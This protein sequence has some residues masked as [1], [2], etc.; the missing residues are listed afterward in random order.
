MYPRKPRFRRF[1]PTL[2]CISF[3][4]I[5]LFF[6]SPHVAF[7]SPAPPDHCFIVG[8]NPKA[9]ALWQFNS[10]ALCLSSSVCLSTRSP[11]D[12]FYHSSNFSSTRCSVVNPAFALLPNTEHLLT[13]DFSSCSKFQHEK[14]V[15]SH[16]KG[17]I[18]DTAECP[19]SVEQ[20][21]PLSLPTIRWNEHFT[22]LV[23]SYPYPKNIFHFSYLVASLPYFIDHLPEMIK[24]WSTPHEVDA[25]NAMYFRDM[26]VLVK[27]VTILMRTPESE[28]QNSRWQNDLLQIMI[29]HRL[30][31]KGINATLDFLSP[32]PD[33][34]HEY[35]CLRNAL[36]LGEQGHVN[37]WPFPNTTEI[38]MDGHSVHVDA[39]HFKRAVYKATKKVARLPEGNGGV[40]ELPPL[41][42]GYA[43]RVGTE[44]NSTK[45]V[46]SP[47]A[48]RQFSA[49]DEEWFCNMLK[50]E[51]DSAGVN[52]HVFTP[53]G[54]E[55]L[56]E[57]VRNIIR[58][59]F[60]VGIHGANLVNS[61][62]MHPFGALLEILPTYASSRCYLG[63]MNS[64]L[65][66]YRHTSTEFAAAEESGCRPQQKA[67]LNVRYRRVKIG[68]KAD[69]DAVRGYVQEGLRHLTDLHKK[70]P[71]GIPVKY[72]PETTY[73]DID[74]SR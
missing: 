67:C 18:N 7:T 74:P 43:R 6:F 52:L 59:G 26:P 47:G 19:E 23:P 5:S 53:T 50:N 37:L 72:N 2:L 25:P 3:V 29:E 56:E 4:I 22:I 61:I 64:G 33:S 55:T 34:K 30:R 54:E 70:Y 21:H 49:E 44:L 17:L 16:G 58:I 32:D 46:G 27:H 13:R 41:V 71:Q 35:L 38:P 31:A 15:C 63:G 11:D 60:V 62:F 45:E 68:S 65:A 40:S 24:L 66:Y 73:Y 39:I 12:S 10:R 8:Y 51:T 28:M 9:P 14:V 36:V 20:V 42:L 57:Q 69:R 1:L 48:A